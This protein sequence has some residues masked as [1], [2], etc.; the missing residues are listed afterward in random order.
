ME[1]ERDEFEM[2]VKNLHHNSEER[3]VHANELSHKLIAK[4]NINTYLITPCDECVRKFCKLQ[5]IDG[6]D[7]FIKNITV[8][9]HTLN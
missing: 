3:N 9:L 1:K 4:V 2:A 5:V 8:F 6:R 7:V